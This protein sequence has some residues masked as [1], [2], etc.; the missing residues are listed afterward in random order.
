MEIETCFDEMEEKF[1]T[2]IV[3]DDFS[4]SFHSDDMGRAW[5]SPA[6][7]SRLDH[8]DQLVGWSKVTE[9][10][11][12]GFMW[13]G[14]SRRQPGK[15]LCISSQYISLVDCNTGEITECDADYDEENHIAISSCLPDEVVGIYGEYGGC[16]VQNTDKGERITV[17]KQ[18]E[19]YGNKIVIRVKVYFGTPDSEVEIHN[20]YGY[21][22]CSFSPCGNYFVFAE[23]AGI[24]ILKRDSTEL[25]E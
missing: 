18:E 8:L 7:K 15:L 12:G 24:I 20:N 4:E 16:P 23:D 14:F 5:R 2:Y 22:T 6:D 9:F 17:Q 10:T 1:D 11:V 13:V 25:G 3:E 21:Y 19:L